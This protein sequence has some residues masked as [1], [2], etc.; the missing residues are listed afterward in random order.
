MNHLDSRFEPI[1]EQFRP[2]GIEKVREL[3]ARLKVPLPKGYV[4]FLSLYGGCGFSGD[5]YV[6]F[7]GRKLPILTFFDDRTLFSNLEVYPDLT[8]E[9]KFSVADDMAG[10]PYVLDATTGKVFFIDF[11][12]NPPLGIK[13]AASFDEFLAAIE[14]QPFE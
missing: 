2:I 14:V 3:E 10:N 7:N 8:A 9:S 1:H 11:S 5:A 4:A 12:V 13:I 6:T